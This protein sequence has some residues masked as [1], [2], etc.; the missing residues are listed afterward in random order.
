[1]GTLVGPGELA[2]MYPVV[3]S[4]QLKREKD[5][6]SCGEVQ[7][8]NFFLRKWFGLVLGTVTVQTRKWNSTA[9]ERSVYQLRRNTEKERNRCVQAVEPH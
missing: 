2:V 6:C 4:R 8:R 5:N 1:M 9:R 3:H 7:R